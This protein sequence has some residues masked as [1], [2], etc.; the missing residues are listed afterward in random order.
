V[1]GT[2]LKPSRTYG[3]R[4]GLDVAQTQKD[5]NTRWRSGL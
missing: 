5:Q 2:A 3:L 4:A 1:E